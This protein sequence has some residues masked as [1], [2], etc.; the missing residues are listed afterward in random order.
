MMPA[1]RRRKRAHASEQIRPCPPSPPHFNWDTIL[2]D[3]SFRIACAHPSNT[4]MEGDL[5]R[6]TFLLALYPSLLITL[7]P[8]YSLGIQVPFIAET[9]IDEPKDDLR[10]VER[11]KKLA[12]SL[13]TRRAQRTQRRKT[14][15]ES[16]TR[17]LCGRMAR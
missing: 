10:N 9:P 5:R 8:G 15:R 7:T 4:R 3:P 17:L 16:R 13:S 12:K 14:K 6:P 1:A 2:K 11:L